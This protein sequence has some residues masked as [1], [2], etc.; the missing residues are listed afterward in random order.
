M[1]HTFDRKCQGGK[2]VLVNYTP[3]KV[4]RSIG[5]ILKDVKK[6]GKAREWA[7]FK[8]QLGKYV[9]CLHRIGEHERARKA[10]L[11]A[12]ILRFLEC[13]NCESK[14][15]IKSYFCR[16]P[17]CPICLWRKSELYQVQGFKMME[18]VTDE[19]KFREMFSGEGDERFSNI[20]VEDDKFIGMKFITGALTIRNV[21]G[22]EAL[23]KAR[24]EMSE[25]WNRLTKYKDFDGV[26][27]VWIRSYE[28]TRND[29]KKSEWYGSYHLHVHFL[30]GVPDY[31][32]SEH[33]ERL[34]NKFRWIRLWK[35]AMKLDYEPS[36][37]VHEVYAR[38]GQKYHGA[39]CEVL[40]YTFKSSD[41][42]HKDPNVT[43]NIVRDLL[44]AVKGMR[45][46]GMCRLLSEVRKRLKLQDIEGKKADLVGITDKNEGLECLR[47]L[48]GVLQ[49]V[50]YDWQYKEG[51][52]RKVVIDSAFDNFIWHGAVEI[53]ATVGILAVGDG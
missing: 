36:V 48:N 42:L 8:R 40:K 10:A 29:D 12:N 4:E 17:L 18:V 34:T 3:E 38:N 6:S 52:Y 1:S 21:H 14:K 43:D 28:H 33:M 50:E 27:K 31:L 39:L 5:E 13:S 25:G 46:V 20:L 19:V 41:Y 51:V 23:K 15:L 11:C 35:K 53:G 24:N 37:H 44:K 49:E 16:I 45:A 32:L 26:A 7:M 9:K 22:A 47:C 2:S 30:M